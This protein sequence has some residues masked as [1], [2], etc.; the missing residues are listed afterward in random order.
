LLAFLNLP[1]EA[2][3]KTKK[4]LQFLESLSI[5]GGEDDMIV[6]YVK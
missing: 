4:D 6:S 5:I 1:L 3:F 2:S